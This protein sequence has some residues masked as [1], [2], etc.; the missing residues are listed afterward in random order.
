[1]ASDIGVPFRPPAWLERLLAPEGDIPYGIA[2]AAG[3]LAAFPQ[4]GLM[5]AVHGAA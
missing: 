3:A 1:M 5:L 2:I 4:S